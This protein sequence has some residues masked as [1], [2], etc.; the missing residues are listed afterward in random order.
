M[1]Q[2]LETWSCTACTFVNASQH[3]ACKI[4]SEE[5]PSSQF[6]PIPPLCRDLSNEGKTLFTQSQ[7]HSHSPSNYISNNVV[8]F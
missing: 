2:F 1:S 7:N 8:L 5:R 3:L 4:C 6:I